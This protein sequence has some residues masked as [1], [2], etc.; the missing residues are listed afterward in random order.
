MKSRSLSA[1]AHVI[2]LAAAWAVCSY[3]AATLAAA[4]AALALA[5][6][7]ADRPAKPRRGGSRTSTVT[8]NGD[9]T[10]SIR[11]QRGPGW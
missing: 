2:V 1:A 4:A 5:N 8:F 3:F 6:F 10:V 9:G 7:A 11:S